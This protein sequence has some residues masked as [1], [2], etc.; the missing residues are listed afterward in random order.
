MILARYF[1]HVWIGVHQELDALTAGLQQLVVCS[2]LPIIESHLHLMFWG[3]CPQA[4]AL[5]ERCRILAFI[6]LSLLVGDEVQS[7]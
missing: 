1:I 3:A 7:L 4:H 2:G 5:S 6:V